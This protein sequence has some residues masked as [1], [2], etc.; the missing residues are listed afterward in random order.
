MRYERVVSSASN[1][2]CLGEARKMI[3]QRTLKN[4]IR[5]TGVGLHS[6]RKVFLT[7]RPAAPD[8]GIVFRRDDLDPVVEIVARAENVGETSLST[9]LVKDSVRYFSH[10]HP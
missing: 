6:G 2:P 5:A 7:L 1:Q 4:V 9:C 3:K 8:T 10:T